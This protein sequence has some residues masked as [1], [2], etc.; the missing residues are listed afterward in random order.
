MARN[1]RP[2]GA[3]LPAIVV[4]RLGPLTYLDVSGQLWK[5]HIDH[6]QIQSDI[7]SDSFH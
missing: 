2:G 7:S 1:L 3:W 5:H 4:E 6:L